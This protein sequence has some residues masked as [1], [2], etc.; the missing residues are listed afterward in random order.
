MKWLNKASAQE[1]NLLD[2][3]L[4]LR[5]EQSEISMVDNFAKHAKIQRKINAIDAELSQL[6]SDRQANNLVSRLFFQYGMKLPIGIV[7]FIMIIVYRTRPVLILN[8]KYDL[9][10][11][12]SLI[13]YPLQEVNSISV[14]VWVI[15]CSGISKLIKN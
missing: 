11:F 3:K 5:K 15:C 14:H 2:Q 4:Q 12:S 10:P 9:F 13:S 1:R 6:K 8:E 7:L